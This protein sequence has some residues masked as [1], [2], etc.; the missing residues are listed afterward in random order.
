MN[1]KLYY[2]EYCLGELS[3]IDNKYIWTPDANNIKSAISNYPAGME[4][5]FLPTQKTAFNNIPYHYKD[6]IYQSDRP[7]LVLKAQIKNTDTDF[8]KLYKL[9][10]L[11]YFTTEF[12]IKS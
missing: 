2:K 11:T 10:K 8:E 5:F 4:M 9:A 7:D 1:V 3:Y 12:I 6:F